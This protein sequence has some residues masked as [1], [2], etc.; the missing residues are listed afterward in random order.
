MSDNLKMRRFKLTTNGLRV[1]GLIFLIFGMIGRAI[2]QNVFLG[3]GTVT[4][5]EL[6]EAMNGS[7][8]VVQYASI[9]IILQVLEACAAPIFAFLLVEG[10]C[11]THDF[12][13]YILRVAG[14]AVLSEVPFDLVQSGKLF[15]LGYQNPVFGLVLCLVMLYFYQ[16]YQGKELKNVLIKLLVTAAAFLWIQM[17]RIQDGMPLAVL[18]AVIWAFRKRPMLRTFAGCLAACVCTLFSL[19]Y[20]IAPITFLAIHLYS[21]ER[22]PANKWVNYLSYPILLLVCGLAGYFMK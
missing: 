21:G 15:D 6:L 2:I 1:W 5:L 13:A 7:E 10:F 14:V 4:G 19:Y 17:L 11:H 8:S 18:T 9:A 20:M 3:I 22:G 16:R 12:K